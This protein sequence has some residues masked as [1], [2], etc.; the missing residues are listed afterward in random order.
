MREEAGTEGETR[1]VDGVFFVRAGKVAFGFNKGYVI[2]DL[3]YEDKGVWLAQGGVAQSDEIL[4]G[5]VEKGFEN[6]EVRTDGL[7]NVEIDVVRQ[8]VA[9]RNIEVE[10]RAED[11]VMENDDLDDHKAETGFAEGVEA[12]SLRDHHF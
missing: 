7:V 11:V 9:D 2:P 4:P 10:S 3:G 12:T 1:C 6:V 8:G 5:A